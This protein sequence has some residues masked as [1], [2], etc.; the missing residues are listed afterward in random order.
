MA[1]C[2]SAIRAAH[3]NEPIRVLE[4][5]AGGILA[6]LRATALI[7]TPPVEICAAVS[8][9]ESALL[10]KDAMMTAVTSSASTTELLRSTSED[11]GPAVAHCDILEAW[12]EAQLAGRLRTPSSS[13]RLSPVSSSPFE[14]ILVQ[15]RTPVPRS[16]ER[17]RARPGALEGSRMVDRSDF[18][19]ECW[20]DALEVI[21]L[22]AS[23]AAIR[24]VRVVA[25]SIQRAAGWARRL[26]PAVL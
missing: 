23:A 5:A 8:S 19:G 3:P 20:L 22:S 24:D 18:E 26:H 17:D 6:G 13:L 15:F 11:S 7:P 2:V 25:V 12:I 9:S 16:R 21:A 10:I 14:R 1:V 4:F